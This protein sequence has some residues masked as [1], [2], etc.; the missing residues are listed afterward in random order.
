MPIA[1][2]PAHPG[3]KCLFG[4][5]ASSD[6]TA[7]VWTS[8]IAAWRADEDGSMVPIT[9]VG[10]QMEPIDLWGPNDV[11]RIFEP[12]ETIPPEQELIAMATRELKRRAE[13]EA[14]KR[15]V[16]KT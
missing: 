4:S 9:A 7:E 13:A 16:R 11:I 6:A 3:W 12:D 15:A 1:I 5:L 8:A 2:I 14:A 10:P